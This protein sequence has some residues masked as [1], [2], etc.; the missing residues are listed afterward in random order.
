M[1]G[2]HGGGL[3]CEGGA[4]LIRFCEFFD[5]TAG[6]GGGIYADGGAAP[7]VIG[8]HIHGNVVVG[9]GGG[10]GVEGGASPLITGCVISGNSAGEGGGVSVGAGSA[11]IEATTI[12]DN[13]C[14]F[15]GGIS[16]TS[17]E[18]VTVTSTVI[19]GNTASIWGGGLS[20]VYADAVFRRCTLAGN[21][22]D[23]AALV[24]MIDADL[25]IGD[26]ILAAN[27]AGSVFT[28]E[29]SSVLA[30]SYSDLWHTCALFAG[31]PP[32]G[33]GI[34]SGVN[35]NGDS[36]DAYANIVMD[37]RFEAS[38]GGDFHLGP[39]SPCIDAG[40]PSS[41]A[42]PDASI[43]DM[44]AFPAA[45]RLFAEATHDGGIVRLSW[46][47]CPGASAHWVFGSDGDAYFMPGAGPGFAHRLAVL[48]PTATDWSTASGPG[49]PARE[50]AF[51]VAAV[52]GSGW[53][54]ARSNRVGERD[55]VAILPP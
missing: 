55:F 12:T 11:A 39:D 35:T 15:G 34:P 47:A 19:A 25:A 4:P 37:P 24:M 28:L 30:V 52:N 7:R 1:S 38:G 26:A 53:E 43:A 14:S 3:Y 44:G 6:S 5:N 9:P 17:C 46:N 27:D 36:C 45:A 48:G 40:D 31:E 41:P 50:W 10:I 22:S 29:G 23:G 8:C 18:G 49:D 32:P 33:L 51:L 2:N 42:D 21:A 54:L 13:Y 16:L 20:L